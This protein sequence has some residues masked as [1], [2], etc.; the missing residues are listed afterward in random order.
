MSNN[1]S[2][3]S[4]ATQSPITYQCPITGPITRCQLESDNLLESDNPLAN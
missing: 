3:N 1:E 2:D 4:L